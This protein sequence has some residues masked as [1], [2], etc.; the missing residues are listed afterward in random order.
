MINDTYFLSYH[1]A[2]SV[3]TKCK[4]FTSRIFFILARK[5][6]SFI[7]SK[8][9]SSNLWIFAPKMGYWVNQFS[10]K[11]N[12]AFFNLSSK[13]QRS[14][15]LSFSRFSKKSPKRSKVQIKTVNPILFKPNHF[16]RVQSKYAICKKLSDKNDNLFRALI[17]LWG[18]LIFCLEMIKWNQKHY[19]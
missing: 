17:I 2:R 11:K 3:I 16:F 4:W 1:I 18:L 5:I 6:Q 9:P 7:A 8:T 12:L 13:L 10:F 14:N 19:R 15:N